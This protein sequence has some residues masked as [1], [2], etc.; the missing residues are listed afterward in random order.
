M[1]GIAVDGVA[2]GKYV[3]IIDMVGLTVGVIDG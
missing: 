2:E 1:V 3:G